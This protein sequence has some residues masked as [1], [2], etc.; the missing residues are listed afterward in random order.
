MGA[1]LAYLDKPNKEIHFQDG[2][3]DFLKYVAGEMQGWRINMVSQGIKYGVRF[4]IR[5]EW[6]CVIEGIFLGV[7]KILGKLMG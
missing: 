2:E 6:S 5:K 1:S 7:K 4:D 3:N